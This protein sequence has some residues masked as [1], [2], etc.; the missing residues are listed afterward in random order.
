[1]SIRGAAPTMSEQHR[2]AK[3]AIAAQEPGAIRLNDLQQ[4]YPRVAFAPDARD[5]D[6]QLKAELLASSANMVGQVTYGKEDLAYLKSKHMQNEELQ[7]DIWI[8]G[9]FDLTDP[10]TNRHVRELIPDFYEKQQ[11]Y[12]DAAID[13]SKRWTKINM[14]GIQSKEDIDF[15][16]L[17]HTQ[18][19]HIPVGF[20][21]TQLM[22]P[23]GLD[24]KTDSTSEDFTV[25]GRG[26]FNPARFIGHG[27]TAVPGLGWNSRNP[28][29]ALTT[30][31]TDT[32]AGPQGI[33]QGNYFTRWWYDDARAPT[34]AGVN[35]WKGFS[36][37][38]SAYANPAAN[39]PGGTL[40]A[41]MGRR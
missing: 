23:L 13:N 29:N 39:V 12:F 21:P 1:M 17:L 9:L 32:T 7:K 18:Q 11:R 27:R 20:L 30:P 34:T 31:T 35:Q 6:V 14:M 22:T 36:K 8:A 10:A 38:P 24:G 28:I 3:Q 4:T 15:L 33:L 19:I 5:T 16:W 26:L 2:A 25:K 41:V 40:A 37:Q